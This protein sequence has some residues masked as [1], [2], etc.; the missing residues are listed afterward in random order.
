MKKLLLMTTAFVLTASTASTAYAVDDSFGNRFG[1]SAPNA[2]EDTKEISIDDISDLVNIAP[3]AG[4]ESALVDSSNVTIDA[5]AGSEDAQAQAQAIAAQPASGIGVDVK[6]ETPAPT[7]E[8]VETKTEALPE[9]E[10]TEAPVAD[11]IPAAPDDQVETALET[12]GEASPTEP[13][14]DEPA[15]TTDTETISE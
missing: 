7:N 9:A 8:I 1:N 4:D 6:I 2:L 13:K 15:A 11:E 3:A 14:Q 12:E 5:E 10:K